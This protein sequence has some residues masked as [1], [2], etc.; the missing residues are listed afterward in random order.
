M[1]RKVGLSIYLLATGMSA[2][3]KKVKKRAASSRYLKVHSVVYEA[4]SGSSWN[5]AH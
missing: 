4:G 1:A 3:A 2:P 5:K